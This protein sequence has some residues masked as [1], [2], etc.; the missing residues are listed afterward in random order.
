MS[1]QSHLA[2]GR[3]SPLCDSRGDLVADPLY[4]CR[5]PSPLTAEKHYPPT[6]PKTSQCPAKPRRRSNPRSARRIGRLILSGILVILLWAGLKTWR[7]YQ[8]AQSLLDVEPKH[9]PCWPGN[10]P[11]RSRCGEGTG[12]PARRDI[13]TCTGWRLFDPLPRPSR[14]GS[15]LWP[16]P[17][18][19]PYLLNMADAGSGRQHW[20][21]PA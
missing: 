15:A 10:E 2:I 18:R 21:L 16:D 7:V 8:A 13:A 4:H 1:G 20:P 14:V 11:N 12:A 9:E 3:P 17:R 6:P 5:Q 19:T